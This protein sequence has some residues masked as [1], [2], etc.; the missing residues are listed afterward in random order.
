MKSH[1]TMMLL[2]SLLLLMQDFEQCE[3]TLRQYHALP[4]QFTQVHYN[5]T[6]YENSAAKTYVGHPVK[7][8]IYITSSLWDIKYKIISG[9]S[10]NLFKAEEYILGDFCFL[11]IRTKGGNTAILNR[12]VKDHYTLTVKAI[13]KNTNAEALTNVRVQV[14]DTN[15]LRPLFSPTS[16]SVSLSENTA[17]RTSI[18]K[19]SAT[20]A[21]IGT[22]GEFYYS[23]KERTDMFAI[24]PTSGVVILTG[25]LDYSE[26]KVDELEVLAVD[27]GMKLYG[28]SGI[29]SMARL[30]IHIEQANEHAPVI[31]ALA[32]TPSELDKDPAYAIITVEDKDHGLNGEVASLSIVAGDPLQQFK[33]VRTFPGGKEYKIKAVGIVEWENQPFGFNLTLQAKDKGNPPKFSSVKAIYLPPPQFRSGIVQFERVVYRAEISEF[34]PP[35]T[36]V[37][38][39]KALPTYPYI[40]YLFVNEPSKTQFSLNPDT[41]L[42]TTLN[43]IKAQHAPHFEFDIMTSDRKASTKVFIKVIDVNTH[44]PEFTQTSYKAS[45]NENVPIGTSVMSVSAKDLDEGENGYVTY[46]IANI[47]PVP[48]EINHFTG[49]LTTSETMDYELMPRI[50]KLRIRASDW[51]TPY[52]REVEVPVTIALNNLNDN[53]PLFEKINCEGTIPRELGVGEQITTVSAIDADELQLVQY[54]IESGNELDLFSL[55]PNSGVLFLKQS[56]GDGLSSKTSFHSL[57]ITATDGENF[58]APIFINIT[59]VTS[60]KP[61]S[62][63]CEETGVAKMLAEKLLQANK[64]NGRVEVEDAFFDTHTMNLHAPQFESSLPRSIE[65]KEDK[66]VNST[67]IL[68]NAT[69]RDTGFNGKLIYSISGGNNDSSFIVGMETGMLKILSPLDREIRDKYTLNVTVYDL[70]IPQKSNWHLLNIRVLDANDNPPE[71]LQDSYF[72][73][74][75]ENKELN[76]EVIQ[77]E[78]IDKDLGTNGEVRYSLLTDTN[79]FSIDSVTGIVKVS[80]LLDREV[81]AVYFLKIEARD[82]AKESPQLS[83][84]VQLKVSLEDVNDNPPKFVPANYRVKIREDLPEGTIVMWLETYDPDIGQASQVRYSLL[85]GGNGSFDV[86]KLSGAIRIVQGLD[87]EKKQVYNLTVRAKDK[88]K[89]ISLSSTCYVEIEIVDVNENLQPPR[90]PNFVDKSF[91]SEDVPIGTSVM[92]LSAYDEDTGRDGE[93][94]YSIRDGSGIGIFRIDE[95]KG[96]IFTVDLLDRE[97]TSH[98]WLTVYATDQGVIPLS[99]F[100]EIYIEIGD[101]NDNA[102]QTTQPVYYPEVMENSPK[103][104]SIIQIEAFDSDSS[105]NEK[106]TYKI[107]SGNPQGFF[108]INPKTELV[109]IKIMFQWLIPDGLLSNLARQEN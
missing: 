8:G 68:L 43:A 88:G 102:P 18:A 31:T 87:F 99:S 6:V 89:P 95:E 109:K 30:T 47:N 40:K 24:H 12:E 78:A 60:R 26:T 64:L 15:D 84:T 7:M 38:M 59:V 107:S 75:S 82:Q 29:S 5:A 48:F 53:T 103:D 104:I 49:V 77:I 14:L 28:S 101:V 74:V 41:G 67:I 52:R 39:V 69:D 33:A 57:K 93:I 54:Q 65:V 17:I 90:F 62:L 83:S 11:R 94:R 81:Q 42:I 27:R 1:L 55:N 32:F 3:G 16:Y 92:T 73:D 108:H 58:A 13:E 21:D 79:K 10:E 61:V 72:V 63:Q 9:D 19:V 23:F 2:L 44:P 91:V 86:D 56:L 98:Y 45:F 46:S 80:G 66:P 71:F 4:M 51:G 20:D 106:L 50:Y 70:G 34:A 97:T 96:T 25:R 105:S 100:I 76:T 22:N 35:N 37:V 36:P 85:D